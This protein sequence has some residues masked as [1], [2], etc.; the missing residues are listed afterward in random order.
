MIKLSNNESDVQ[1]KVGEF[2]EKEDF[3]RG[4]VR[5]S[6]DD[7]KRIGIVEGDVV[8]IEGKRKTGAIAVRAYPVDVGLDIIRM[9]GLER[10]NCG[11]GIGEVVKVKSADV[12]E[13]KTVTIAPARKGI[14]IHMGY[15][16]MKQ[17]LLI[18]PVSAGDVIRPIPVVK[19][20]RSQKILFDHFLGIDFGNF[21][22]TPFGEEKFVII[23]T[24]PKGIVRITAKTDVELKKILEQNIIS[25][26]DFISVKNKP[27]TKNMIEVTGLKEIKKLTGGKY[28]IH[29]YEDDKIAIYY[30]KNYFL[31]E[32]KKQ[33]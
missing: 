13:A 1:L 32:L 29:K 9:D 23:N 16:L 5:I 11:A 25:E 21:L 28:F 8:E 14:I 4:I 7:M 27:E 20:K 15:N 30:T 22:F 10:R 3:D 33:S 2:T 17:N 31:Q 24:E 12:K 6:K 19:D 26:Q 18:R